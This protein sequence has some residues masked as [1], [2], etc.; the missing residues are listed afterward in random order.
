[1]PLSLQALRQSTAELLACALCDLFP[2]TLLVN[3]VVTDLGFHYDCVLKNPI[4][5]TA[6]PLI[7][8]R[9]RALIRQNIPVKTLEMMR[10]NAVTYFI[11]NAQ[12]LKAE[13]ISTLP[14]NVVQIF[15]MGD[16]IDFCPAPY[17]AHTSEVKAFKLHG[18]EN[19]LFSI[20]DSDTYPVTRISGTAFP[21]TYALKNFLKRSEEA[22]KRDHQEIGTAMELFSNLHDSGYWIWRPKGVA[23]QNT[24]KEWW[25]TVHQEEGF[26]SIATGPLVPQRLIKP[27]KNEEL[28][29]A[30]V[31]DHDYFICPDPT[32]LHVQLLKITDPVEAQ[33]PIRY[34]SF[35]PVCNLIPPE[36]A[37]GL[38]QPPNA[39]VDTAHIFCNRDQLLQEL[40][41]SLQ[42]INKI[43]K[44]FDFEER[45]RLCAHR[46]SSV[47]NKATWNEAV[48]SLATALSACKISYI[49]DKDQDTRYGP[50]VEIGLSDALG[51]YW[52]G[53]HVAI[54]MLNPEWFDLSYQGNDGS[55]HRLAM[56]TRSTFGS[57]ERFI[58]LLLERYAGM[59][60]L[61]LTPEQAR[62]IPVT[63]KYAAY[64]AE[65][66]GAM[67]RAGLRI[68]MD[69]RSSPLAERV[70][71]A[72][73]A[74]VPYMIMI[75]DQE[76]KKHLITVR[77]RSKEKVQS[78]VTRESFLEQLDREGAT[79]S[80]SQQ[81]QKTK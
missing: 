69:Y 48:E 23:L 2:D 45:W 49:L 44:L 26:E 65:V 37:A 50:R 9:M 30:D 28:C 10:Q 21:D 78:G 81:L 27:L 54:D 77:S 80:L 47:G 63:P 14:N 61:W 35:H 70:R 19:A 57:L 4:D 29:E 58:A 12:R 6:L 31:A 43:T 7:E 53:A 66:H 72:E 33:L 51:R 13:I 34:A 64:A 3:S 76:E 11:H 40:I 62:V 74:R 56:I 41:S 15:Q 5:E 52:A 59:L 55:A 16:F 73:Q 42:F 67:K 18:I 79:S 68:G 46:P 1:M 8:E 20:R 22:K 75:G 60:P 38:F 25:Q 24:L 39:Q 17:M 71:E 36:Q 32:Q